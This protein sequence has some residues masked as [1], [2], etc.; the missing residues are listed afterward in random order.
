MA[1]K[2]TLKLCV[3]LASAAVL[4]GCTQEV[5]DSQGQNRTPMNQQTKNL[6]I[7][8][9]GCL[10]TGIGTNQFV[11]TH[12]R[13]QPLAS[14]PSD[15][16]SDVNLSLQNN[17]AVRLALNDDQDVSNLVGQ[18]VSVTGRLTSTGADTIGTAGRA[19][20]VEQKPE[21]RDDKSQAATDQHYSDKVIQEAGPIGQDSMNNGT[22]P[23]VR[24]QQIGGTGESC[25]SAPAADRK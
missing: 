9:T 15:A 3:S 22:Y 21:S 8:L 17:S 6:E 5:S 2:W 19:P 1:K 11:I 13:P 16:L 23:E 12:A 14:Q 18:M 24:V 25:T 20:V 4:V 10:T 7:A